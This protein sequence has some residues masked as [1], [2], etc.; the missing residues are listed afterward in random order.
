[1]EIENGD[2]IS[3]AKISAKIPIVRIYLFLFMVRV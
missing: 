1:M 2:P 3:L